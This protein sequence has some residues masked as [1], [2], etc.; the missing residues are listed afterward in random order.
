MPLAD[1]FKSFTAFFLLVGAIFFFS[2]DD[3]SA[4][5]AG[6]FWQTQAGITEFSLSAEP[7]ERL[8]YDIRWKLFNIGQ[9]SIEYLGEET[10]DGNKLHLIRSTISTLKVR[11]EEFIYGYQ[12]TLLPYL[13][14]RNVSFMGI[15]KKITERYNQKEGTVSITEETGSKRNSFVI[16]CDGFIENAVLFIYKLR[17]IGNPFKGIRAHIQLPTKTLSIHF[18]GIV[19]V[20]NGHSQHMARLFKS[21]K[22][23]FV[24]YIANATGALPLKLRNASKYFTSSE[25]CLVERRILTED[26]IGEYKSSIEK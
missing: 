6:A 25:M 8:V 14:K 13:V 17:N 2:G 11:D 7:G 5:P 1:F 4:A 10:L 18:D 24:C 21:E 12:S 15:A 3:F 19:R 9:A 22:N 20:K 23:E 16:R 26:E